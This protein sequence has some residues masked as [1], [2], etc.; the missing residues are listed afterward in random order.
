VPGPFQPLCADSEVEFFLATE[1]PNGAPHSGITRRQTSVSSFSDNDRVKSSATGGT[2]PWPA[3]RY[4]NMWVCPLGG[5]LLGY[6]QFPGGPAATDGVVITYTAFGTNGTAQAPFHL[7][8]TATHEVGHYLNLYH[9]WGDDGSGCGGTDEVDDTPNQG[10]G[11]TGVPTFPRISC[12]NGPNGDLYV[13]Y[14]DYVN[15]PVMVMFTHGQAARMQACLDGPR[16]S[17]G[18]SSSIRSH[19]GPIVSWGP[20]RVDAFVVGTT[21]ECFHK[22]QDGSVWGPSET[23]YES[24]GGICCSPIEAISWGSG[25][26]DL[27]VIGTDARLWHKW[28]SGAWGPSNTGWESLGGICMSDPKAVSWSLDRLDLFVIGTDSRLYH[29]WWDGSSW[30]PSVDGFE[31]LGG[32]CISKPEVVAWGSN[33]LDVFVV[34]TD[35]ALYHKWWDGSAWGPSVDGFESLGGIC[36]GTPQVASWG[37]NRLDVFVVGTDSRLY[38]KWWDGSSWG[39]SVDGF[40]SLGGICRSEP[41]VIAWGPNRLDVFVIGTD[42]ALYHKWWD[43][44]AWG[45]SVD[46]YESLGGTCI[47]GPFVT[48]SAPNRLDVFVTGTDNAL[49]QRS[50]NGSTWSDWRYLGG[51]VLPAA[52]LQEEPRPPEPVATPRPEPAPGLNG[53][54]AL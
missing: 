32:I 16:A 24:L 48:S 10:G 45:P 3:E 37:P 28:W 9:I 22:W 4:L 2:D 15:D 33:R 53:T 44:S 26:L 14:M 47:A 13:N 31:S 8:R 41:A 50:W 23:G 25:R 19:S 51:V 34:G 36:A 12:N 54:A 35:H 43:G 1:D 27:F 46:G 5:G 52:R 21:S 11:N 30:G 49:Y 7:G 6:A 17:L 29:K 20:D 42:R 18:S 40:E 38:H 39:P